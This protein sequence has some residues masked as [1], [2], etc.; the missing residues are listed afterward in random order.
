MATTEA[1]PQV[2]NSQEVLR[3]LQTSDLFR[4]ICGAQYQKTIG[5]KQIARQQFKLSLMPNNF[6]AGPGRTPPTV[7]LPFLIQRFWMHDGHFDFLDDQDT[8]LRLVAAGGFFP[9]PSGLGVYAGVVAEIIE[10]LGWL[11]G[12]MD[13]VVI[14]GITTPP[15][16]FAN[17]F[18]FRVVDPEGKLQGARLSPVE[19]EEPDPDYTYSSILNLMAKMYPDDPIVV[20]PLPK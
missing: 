15:D 8:G 5:T 3:V 10:G 20:E 1:A 17:L 4:H 11:Q 16:Q 14:N 13:N 19:A 12:L 18:T 7:L 6:E 9:A 2:Q